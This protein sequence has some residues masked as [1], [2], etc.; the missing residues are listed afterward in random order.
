MHNLMLNQI[1]NRVWRKFIACSILWEDTP[2][3]LYNNNNNNTLF[4]E[5]NTFS[6]L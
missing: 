5:S 2:T 6:I 1:T 3:F 4:K